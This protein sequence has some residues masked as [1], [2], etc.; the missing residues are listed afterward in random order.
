MKS[1]FITLVFLF[2]IL[3]VSCSNTRRPFVVAPIEQGNCDTKQ[4]STCQAFLKTKALGS[5]CKLEKL[6]Q[7][8]AHKPCE[9]NSNAKSICLDFCQNGGGAV[10][11]YNEGCQAGTK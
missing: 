5:N 1:T 9:S 7:C 4:F 10:C 2:A 3:H 8:E 11:N 6:R